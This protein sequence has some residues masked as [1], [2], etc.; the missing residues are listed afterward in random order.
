[1]N[2]YPDK[3]L[4]WW[5]SIKHHSLMLLAYRILLLLKH[6][7]SLQ[8]VSFPFDIRK[9]ISSHMWY[10]VVNLSLR[11]YSVFEDSCFASPLLWLGGVGLHCGRSWITLLAGIIEWAVKMNN[12]S[13]NTLP[14]GDKW[15][16]RKNVQEWKH[17]EAGYVLM[18]ALA[19]F[20]CWGN[21]RWV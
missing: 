17:T 13:S 8:H 15:W 9:G 12:D 2:L 4:T 16:E 6:K 11:I 21:W 7:M 19:R 5:L 20:C 14:L 3:P 10:K 18:R 1:M